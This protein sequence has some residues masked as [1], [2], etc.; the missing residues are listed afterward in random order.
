VLEPITVVL[1]HGI[2]VISEVCLVVFCCAGIL[3]VSLDLRDDFFV[4]GMNGQSQVLAEMRGE[5]LW[6]HDRF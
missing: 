1:A 3:D 6:C 5:D 2:E 4:E